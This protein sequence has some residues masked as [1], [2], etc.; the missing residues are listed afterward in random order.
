[1]TV[2]RRAVVVAITA[3]LLALV[4]ITSG[5]AESGFTASI[6]NSSNTFGSGTQNLTATSAG[7]TQCTTVGSTATGTTPCTGSFFPGSTPASGTATNS[8]TL[9]AGGTVTPSSS[10]FTASSCGPLGFPNTSSSTNPLLA[11]YAAGFNPTSGPTAVAGSGSYAADGTTSMAT[12]VA[13][14]TN[15]QNFTIGAWFKT[16]VAGG[17]II[18]FEG[19]YSDVATGNFDRLLFLN[20]SGKV[21]FGV[22]PLGIGAETVKLVTSPNSYNDGAWHYAVATASYALTARSQNLYVDGGLVASTTSLLEPSSAQVFNGYWRVGQNRNAEGFT[23]S[24]NYFTGSLSN[25]GTWPT[26]LSGTQISSLYSASSQ[27]ALTTLA[28]SLGANN[29]WPLNSD[30]TTSFPGTGNPTGTDPCADVT[31]TVGTATNC[32]YP[33]SAGVCTAATN[34]TLLSSL[35]SAGTLAMPTPTPGTP[36]VVT[37]TTG[38]ATTYKT[39]FDGGLHFVVPITIT[40]KNFPATFTWRSNQTVTSQ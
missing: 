32:I 11:R 19:G 24:R 40:Q 15:P 30:G 2:R 33:A 3:A 27:N 21:V 36:V 28:T 22:N 26:A 20:G 4:A 14:M 1:M 12:S 35:S 10:T 38:R 29:Y 6:R 34:A 37:T 7:T 39:S 31:V 8:V 18:G 23:G 13:L 25:A 9:T 17:G 5:P 16:S